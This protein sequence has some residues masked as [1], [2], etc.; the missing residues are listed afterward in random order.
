MG[1]TTDGA[2]KALFLR[3]YTRHVSLF[4]TEDATLDAVTK[5]KLEDETRK[6]EDKPP[7]KSTSRDSRLAFTAT[8]Q[9][10]S[11]F[12]ERLEK[13]NPAS[14]SGAVTA[15]KTSASARSGSPMIAP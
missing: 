2:K 8:E 3:T 1:D 11:I 13:P 9:A 14:P 6:A 4:L 5:K 10:S 12:R 15:A 7:V